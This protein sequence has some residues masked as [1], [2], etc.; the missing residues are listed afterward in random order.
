MIKPDRH[1][2]PDI[3]VINISAFILMQL[4][5]HYSISYD[6]I[7]GEIVNTLSE[8]ARENCPYAINF[9]FLLDK[10][11]YDNKTDSFKLKK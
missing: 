11:V 3:S 7:V 9:L 4:N 2:N 10:L 8:E 6:K 5:E 1:T